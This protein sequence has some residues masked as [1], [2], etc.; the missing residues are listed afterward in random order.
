MA[1]ATPCGMSQAWTVG[2]NM[3]VGG[4]FSGSGNDRFRQGLRPDDDIPP[5]MRPYVSHRRELP[6][7]A[8]G[9]KVTFGLFLQGLLRAVLPAVGLFGLLAL[10]NFYRAE[11]AAM[12][13][14]VFAGSGTWL[15]L[16]ALCV[17][18]TFLAVHLTSR[19][20]GPAIAAGQVILAW[21]A[22]GIA[23]FIVPIVPAF[24]LDVADTTRVGLALPVALI[25]GQFTS[26]VAFDAARSI[27]WWKGPAYGFLWGC[28]VFALTFFPAAHVGTDAPWLERM[29]EYLAISLAVST[30]LL[31]PYWMARPMVRPLP[32]F[33][34][35]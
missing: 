33:A 30:A 4:R 13:E 1:S 9:T 19:R 10:M 23:A 7:G 6:M 2:V 29:G 27:Q 35:Y 3:N 11:P 32:G 14:P 26:A 25:L 12:F 16:G 28:L 18:L 5:D 8:P 31:V 22:V 21:L 17:P 34:G 24:E 20:Y 15:S